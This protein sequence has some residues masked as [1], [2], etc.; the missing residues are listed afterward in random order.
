MSHYLVTGGAGFI[1]SHLVEL[2]LAEGHS[3]RVIDNLHTGKRERLPSTVE[4]VE[5]DITHFETI[6]R[7]CQGVD[8]VFHLAARP[9]VPYSVEFPRESHEVNADG[10]LNVFIAA[11][12]AGVK[13]VVF[14][15]SSSV[16][17]NTT[18]LPSHPDLPPAPAS[19]YA[20][21][22]Y[23]GEL[24]A[25]QCY[26]LYG[27]ETVSLRY[28]N[29]FGP[30]MGEEGGAYVTVMSVFRRQAKE[31][32]S[33]TVDGDGE[34]SR[35]LVHVTDVARAN[36][37]AM[38]S[39]RVGKG[40]VLNIGTGKA[41]SVNQIAALFNRPIVYTPARKGDVAHTL[42]DISRT[43][44]LIEWEPKTSFEEGIQELLV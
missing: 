33:L 3:V 25:K 19:P 37:L 24:Y 41:Y 29:V 43:R 38:Q 36:L 9:R 16:Y 7:A 28:F 14:T 34:Q 10:S 1:G 11:R 4:F 23:I 20:L 18:V 32:V 40:E 21:Q 44:E 2:L 6:S 35:D 27:L 8:G 31:G 5:G 42:A 12:D 17:G 15:S 13:R 26:A 30:R 22:K 39:S